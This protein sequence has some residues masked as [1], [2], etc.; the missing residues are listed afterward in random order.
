MSR[1]FKRFSQA[2]ASITRQFGGTGLGLSIVKSL[3]EAMGGSVGC[4]S[5]ESVGSTFVVQIPLQWLDVDASYE[6]QHPTHPQADMPYALIVEDNETNFRVFEAILDNFGWRTEHATNGAHA[7][8]AI[9]RTTYD[10]VLMDIHMPVMDGL[11]AMRLMRAREVSD[12]RAALPI[13]AVSANATVEDRRNALDAGANEFLA[14]PMYAKVLRDALLKL[15]LL[16]YTP[17]NREVA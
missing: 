7:L 12:A 15:G 11:T 6:F 8:D 14:K 2:D 5:D 16:A 3:V 1:L 10:L 4:A 17:K 13:I 9:A